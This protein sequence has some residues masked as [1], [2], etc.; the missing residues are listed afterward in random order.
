[1]IELGADPRVAVNRAANEI[2]ASLDAAPGLDPAA[3][4]TL[5]R[6]EAGGRLTA[7]QSKT[8]LSQLLTEGGDPEAIA[9]AHG[10][11]P[12]DTSLIEAAVDAAIAEDEGAWSRYVGGEDK[13]A[14]MFVGKVMK[15][16]GGKADGKAVTAL[17]QQRR[18]AGR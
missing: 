8:V 1:A 13:V 7:T 15:A 2:A 6:M 14:G 3:F 10:F 4:A 5:T 11:A 16:T 9:D 17:L 18:A 12:V